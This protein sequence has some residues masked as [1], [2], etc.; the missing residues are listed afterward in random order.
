MIGTCI[1]VFVA[2][3]LVNF[4]ILGGAG[5]ENGYDG[6]VPAVLAVVLAPLFLV[7]VV[8]GLIIWGFFK[9]GQIIGG[10]NR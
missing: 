2:C 1:G 6:N 8:S 3:I 7:V 4:S 9:F 5:Y 10:H